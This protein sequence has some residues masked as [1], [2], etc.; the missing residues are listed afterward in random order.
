MPMGWTMSRRTPIG[1]TGTRN[2]IT[3]PQRAWLAKEIDS[4]T[5]LHHG[6]C[7]GADAA[8][9]AIGRSVGARIVVHP[10]TDERLMMPV[11][12]DVIRLPAKPY[13]DRN[14]DIVDDTLWLLACPDGIERR[15]SGTWFT[16]RYAERRGTPVLICYPGGTV[17]ELN[18]RHS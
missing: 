14:R 4:D 15:H 9:H 12:P 10:P 8:V 7:V 2:G 3:K 18:G 17:E 5:E 1:F 11:D 6:A 16:I 13:H